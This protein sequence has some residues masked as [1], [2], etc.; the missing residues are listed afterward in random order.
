M[1]LAPPPKP[2]HRPHGGGVDRAKPPFDRRG[3]TSPDKADSADK[4]LRRAVLARLISDPFVSSAHMS[5][6]AVAGAVTLSGYVSSHAQKDAANAA[7]RR[8][9]GVGQIIDIVM[10][11]VPGASVAASKPKGAGP[12]ALATNGSS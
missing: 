9:S 12:L 1:A 2:G 10:I 5:V 8:V 7:A 3:T 4:A 6:E 11:A